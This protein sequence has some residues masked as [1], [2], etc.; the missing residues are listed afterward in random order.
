VQNHRMSARTK[1]LGLFPLG[2]ILRRT[3][4]LGFAYILMLGLI[5]G[6][7]EFDKW[8][9]VPVNRAVAF[10]SILFVLGLLAAAWMEWESRRERR[11]WAVSVSEDLISIVDEKG[12]TTA[13]PTSTLQVVVAV[14]S[15]TAWRDDLD[16]ALFDDCDEPL[17]SFPLM[18][19]GGDAFIK[20]LSGRRGFDA[21]E[22]AAAEASARSTAHAIWVAN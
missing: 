21:T 16:I 18:A 19:S 9:T 7:W 11:R 5:V 13:I 14:A 2:T 6:A 1:E 3:L 10:A 20:W 8:S 15:Q 12:R 17:I 22:F 4:P